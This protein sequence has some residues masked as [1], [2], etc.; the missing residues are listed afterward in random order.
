MGGVANL[1]AP[2]LLPLH[3]SR[4]EKKESRW[5]RC[6]HHLQCR[7]LHWRKSR[8][9]LRHR[10]YSLRDNAR[11]REHRNVRLHRPEPLRRLR[12][13]LPGNQHPDA[14]SPWLHRL[15]NRISKTHLRSFYYFLLSA[16]SHC[17][18]S[19]RIQSNFGRY[20][21]CGYFGVKLLRKK[22]FRRNRSWWGS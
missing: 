19:G 7:P 5:E 15:Q 2:P 4:R 13:L 6:I 1:R 20:W 22:Y 21:I 8:D 14:L 12:K 17:L 10:L 18:F 3:R 16:L 11:V 9:Q